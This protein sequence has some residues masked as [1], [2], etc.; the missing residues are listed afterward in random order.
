M[1]KAHKPMI[2]PSRAPEAGQ[3]ALRRERKHICAQ[4]ALKTPTGSCIDAIAECL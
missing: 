2:N 4:L 1:T 3:A